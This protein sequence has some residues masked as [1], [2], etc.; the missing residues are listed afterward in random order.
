ML[1][2]L[3]AL[4]TASAFAGAALYVNIA[5]KCPIWGIGWEVNGGYPGSPVY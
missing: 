5:C 3:L 4:A 1:S 2:G